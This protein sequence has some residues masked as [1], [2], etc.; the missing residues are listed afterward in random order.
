MLIDTDLAADAVL[1]P[2]PFAVT[3]KVYDVAP[4]KPPKS[5]VSRTV[6]QPSGG[7]ATGLDVTE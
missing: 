5:Q 6:V 1:P 3:R 2:G 7:V 4:S